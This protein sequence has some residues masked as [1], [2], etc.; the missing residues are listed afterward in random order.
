MRLMLLCGLLLCCWISPAAAIA[1]LDALGRPVDLPAVPQRI[2]SLAPSVTE[3]LF[4]LGVGDRVVGVTRYCDYPAAARS[5]TKV[6]GYTNPNLELILTLNPD[7]VIV[8]TGKSSPLLPERLS[9]LGL[10]VFTVAP[11]SLTDTFATIGLLG[12]V[13]GVPEAGRSLAAELENVVFNIKAAV[14]DR[15]PPGVLLCIMVR[16]LRLA[17]PGTLGDDLIRAAGGINL[18][19]PGSEPYPSW[20]MEKLL[21][22]NPEVIIVS[23]HPSDPDPAAYFSA[24]SGLRA[25]R[26]KR[27]VSIEPDWL[28]RPGPRLRRGLTALV[29]AL[30]GAAALEQQGSETK[31]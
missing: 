7:L 17:G 28:H 20:G 6:G 10:P 30:H 26:E 21:R 23:P 13:T 12:E 2:V 1:R 8:S 24:W 22:V 29:D 3:T 16:P 4:A 31:D 19:P 15:K 5:R 11:D 25:V 27:V 14:K 9:E 18:V